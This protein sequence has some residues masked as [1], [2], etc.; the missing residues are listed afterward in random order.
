[1]RDWDHIMMMMMMMMMMMIL[2]HGLFEVVSR[3]Y[4]CA[5]RET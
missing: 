1:M 5:D 3:I 4:I 2:Y